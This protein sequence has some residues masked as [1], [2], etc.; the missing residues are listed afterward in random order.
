M[1]DD[2]LIL[3][4]EDNQESLKVLSEMLY[5]ADYQVAI[6]NSGQTA[7]DVVDKRDIDLILLDIMMPHMSG[8]EVC[9]K[10]KADKATQDI[11]VLFIS[12]LKET[13]NKLKAFEVGGV[14]YITKPFQQ[15]EV[16]ARIETHLKLSATKE[17][18]QEKNKEQQE[19]LNYLRA[20][21]EKFR[22]YV[23]YAP[24]GIFIVDSKGNYLDVNQE[25]TKMTGY[26]SDEILNMNIQQLIPESNLEKALSVFQELL[27]E[28]Q[29]R[30]EIKIRDKAGNILDVILAAK[31]IANNRFLGFKKDITEKKKMEDSLRKKVELEQLSTELSKDFINL[32]EE[33]IE[34]KIEE[35]LEKIGKFMEVDY[36]F[37]YLFS[38]DNRRIIESFEWYDDEQFATKKLAQSRA[39]FDMK[40]FPWFI[41]Q[42]ESAELIDISALDNLPARAKKYKGV[43]AEQGIESTLIFPMKYNNNL[44]GALAF[45]AQEKKEWK[46]NEI[47]LFKMIA[48]I[49]VNVL[50]RKKNEA[51]I[52][53]Y[54]TEL[55][56]EFEKAKQ[57]HQQ[58]LPTDLPEIE[59]IN[60]ATY[61]QP[62]KKLGGDFYNVIEIENSLFFYLADVSGHGLD[63]A[64]MDI[65][66]RETINNYLLNRDNDQQNLKPQ[67]LISYVADKYKDE[68]FPADYFICLLVGILDLSKMEVEFANAGFQ[69]P[70]ILVKNDGQITTLE[71]GGM[72]ISSAVSKDEFS[73]LYGSEQPSLRIDFAPG[74][75]L[76]LTTDGLIEEQVDDEMYGEERLKEVLADNY[77]YPV[78]L[79]NTRVKNDFEEFAGSLTGQDDLTFLSLKRDLEVIDKFSIEISSSIQQIYQVEEHV[80][81]FLAPYYNQPSLVFIGLQEIVTNAIEHGNQMDSTKKVEVEI[82]VTNQD[83]EIIITDNGVGFDWKDRVAK[84]FDIEE[85]LKANRERGRGIKITNQ[86]Y[87]EM[88]YNERGNQ[89]H[90]LKLR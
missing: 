43:L 78:E 69:F 85:E 74:D 26:N 4:V 68:D 33:D 59:E 63:G 86:L 71:S 7:L 57:L 55:E 51:K 28:G 37:I 5:R 60:Y 20:S 32:K 42:L 14:D 24:D 52:N 47:S 18:L 83:I 22:S 46:K 88:W 72:P 9:K 44:I 61:F 12:A 73:A 87:D 67:Q 6:A 31:Q 50:Q 21:E 11:P 70:P 58:F 82:E 19:L 62:S 15:K 25:A 23:D 64:M 3:V 38:P 35:G 29:V 40:K 77:S 76:F 41:E 90:L 2:Q 79:I 54:Y 56:A 30:S 27:A 48:D 1:T 45:D 39:T 49:F 10:L 66:L 81:E 13:E 53:K 16:L 17:E 8:F 36:S 65:F 80:L 89:A 84:K 75:L 34:I